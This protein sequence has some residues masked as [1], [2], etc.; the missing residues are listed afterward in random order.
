[1]GAGM[2]LTEA[3]VKA[4]GEYSPM[5]ERPPGTMVPPIPATSDKSAKLELTTFESNEEKTSRKGHE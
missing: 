3:P 2:Y 1:M 5:G 4:A